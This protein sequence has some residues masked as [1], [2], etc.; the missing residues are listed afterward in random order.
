MRASSLPT[1]LDVDL[2]AK[3]NLRCGF[4]HLSYFTPKDRGQQIA[5]EDFDSHITPLLPHLKSL[6]LFSKYEV[7]TC[8]DFSAIFTRITEHDL[9]TYFSTNGLL[10]NDDVIKTIVGKLTYLTV[11]ATGFTRERYHHYMRSDSFDL[12]E[13]NLGRLNAAKR[14][15]GT[16]FPILR[17]S[18]VAMQSS[19]EELPRAADFAHRHQAAEGVQMTSLYVFEPSMRVELPAADIDRY[20]RMTAAAVD[21]AKTVGV[22]FTLQSGSIDD[23]EAETDTLGHRPCY[24][25]WS[26]LS[27]QPNG[28]VYPCPV[29]YRPVGNMFKESLP[30][31]WRGESLATFRVGV[32]DVANMNEDCRNCMHCRHHPIHDADANDLSGTDTF[33]AGMTRKQTG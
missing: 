12:L 32:N 24:I 6:T 23:N 26:R 17:I 18:T 30:G 15:A 5:V 19:L 31:I 21:Y 13:A 11:S 16:E 4:C 7:L 2:S 33:F 20:N 1:H 27:I 10:L 25:P 22:P 14:R 29:A 28:D 3:C 8:R 9:E